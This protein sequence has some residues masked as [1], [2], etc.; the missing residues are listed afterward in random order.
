MQRIAPLLTALF[1]CVGAQ[2]T[3]PQFESQV[4][5]TFGMIGISHSETARLNLVNIDDPRIIYIIPNLC[6][7]QL[8]FLD[9]TGQ[10]L[11][12]SDVAL[13]NGQAGYLDLARDKISSNGPRAQIRA[14]VATL[15]NPTLASAANCI[16]TI[17][18]FNSRTGQ[19][20]VI[21]PTAPQVRLSQ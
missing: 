15:D 2:A 3:H 6:Q 10:I 17:E 20:K 21:Y 9:E 19:T 11:A 7:A 1:Y 8:R 16:A 18:I 4:V 5:S 12:K 14:E 13:P